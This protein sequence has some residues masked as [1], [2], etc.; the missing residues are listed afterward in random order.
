MSLSFAMPGT[1]TIALAATSSAPPAD[2]SERAA[3]VAASLPAERGDEARLVA[4]AAAGDRE[5]FRELF[6]RYQRPIAALVGRMV[7]SPDDV[8]DILQETFVRAW[9]GLPRFRGDAQFGTWL[10]RIA[11]NTAIKYRSK[12]KSDTAP[13]VSLSDGEG[14]GG[15]LEAIPADAGADPLRGGDPFH[16]AHKC[17]QEQTIRKAVHALP[18]KQKSVVLLHYFEG[19]SCEEISDI[20]GCSL[21]TV[22]SRLHYACKRLK[23]VLGTGGERGEI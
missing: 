23:G 4:R 9:K 19:R 13:L 7:A 1:N 5:A 22:W 20:V 18:D 3:P 10:Y 21:G 15:G 14:G 12:R 16:A 11:V 8:D 17:E 2:P 6:E